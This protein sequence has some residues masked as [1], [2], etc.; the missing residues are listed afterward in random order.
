MVLVDRPGNVVFW[1]A[2][3][4]RHFGA[5]R[6]EYRIRIDLQDIRAAAAMAAE[7]ASAD[8]ALRRADTGSRAG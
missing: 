5:D 7:P 4:A 1:M 2:L 3:V 8:A 6:F